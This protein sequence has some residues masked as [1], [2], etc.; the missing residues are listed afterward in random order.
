M[1]LTK[2]SNK[3]LA[4]DAVTAD[5]IADGT[6]VASDIADGTV[7][8]A[9]LANTAI[10]INGTSIALGASGD[11]V[12]G[13]DWQS[14]ITAAGGSSTAVAGEG[15]FIDTTSATHTL[16]L[17]LSATQGDEITIHDYAG[18]FD[19]NAVTIDRNG[20]N[21]NGAAANGA[22]GGENA[23][24]KL[25]YVDSTQGW[26]TVTNATP[27]GIAPLYI[28]ATGGTEVTNGDYKTH[29]FTS[30]GCFSV[31]QV[32]NPIG[33]GSSV[34]YLVVAG[35][36]GGGL[37]FAGGGGAGGFRLYESG[38]PNPLNSPAGMTISASTYP[39]TVG[40]GGAGGTE[41]PSSDSV[42][43]SNS[44][45]STITSAGGGR[46]GSAGAFSRNGGP[47]GSG[48]GVR[49]NEGCAGS[50]NTPP[51]SPPQGN[52]GGGP[53]VPS[54]AGGGGGA[55]TA[56]GL[57]ACTSGTVGGD[58]GTG[59][60]VTDCFIG[61]TAPSYGE[62]GPAGRYFAGGGASG[63]YVAAGGTAGL[64]GGGTAPTTNSNGDD[65]QT[66]TGGGG[67]GA[68]NESPPR[69]GGTGGS[70]IVMIRYK[71]QN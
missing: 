63:G 48:G 4:D 9:K 51:V 23:T 28:T 11:I 17:P 42:S 59:S 12:A 25:V 22:V 36:G 35:G 45:F 60:F 55:A 71:Y 49:Y 14:V 61:P 37:D 69:D 43:G 16:T 64:G 20:H 6:V 18:T 24:I 15:Y 1:A 5:K 21:L 53:G 62:T 7:T 68:P 47:G 67:G 29:I 34:E 30:S 19:T 50:G 33:S 32:G 58:G 56:G 44:V 8:N 66:N 40:G 39:I 41:S 65:G 10:T 70:G 26:R 54:R 2:V 38:T 52:P 46:A 13:T 27:S 57:G 31:S 3:G